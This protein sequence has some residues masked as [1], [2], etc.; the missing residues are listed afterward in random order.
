MELDKF[1]D[2]DLV[3]DHAN[4]N[5]FIPKKF[6]SV[7]DVKGRTL[8]VQITN[9]GV[10]GALPGATMTAVW[11]NKASGI[12]DMSAFNLIDASNS[13]FRLTYPNHMLTAGKVEMT[14]QVLYSGQTTTLKTFEI[15]VQAVNGTFSALIESQQFSALA[16]A[17]ANVNQ[18]DTEIAKKADETIVSGQINDL[19]KS[20]ADKTF[21]DAMLSSI[22]S[23]GPRELFY[24]LS[25]LKAKY[26]SGTEG[27]YLVFDASHTD[28]AHSYMWKDGAWQD[29]GIYQGMEIA[30]GKVNMSKINFNE[31]IVVGHNNVIDF[32][33]TEKR[34][35]VKF[36]TQ[37]ACL[38]NI[39][40]LPAQTIS[41][42]NE[43]IPWQLRYIIY[44]LDTKNLTAYTAAK[45]PTT[46]TNRDV[47]LFTAYNS[48]VVGGLNAHA[49]LV[50]GKNTLDKALT[51]DLRGTSVDV[52]IPILYEQSSFKITHDAA[53]NKVIFECA[54]VYG[55]LQN[56]KGGTEYNSTAP[57]AK[58]DGVFKK[59]A[60]QRTADS[61]RFANN[62]YLS[63]S[64]K[65]FIILDYATKL[66]DEQARDYCFVMTFQND[67]IWSTTGMELYCVIDGKVPKGPL[68]TT[69]TTDSYDWQ[70][71][72]LVI[73]DNLYYVKDKNYT[74]FGQNLVYQQYFDNDNITHE[75]ALPN[76]I[77]EFNQSGNFTPNLAGTFDSKIVSKHKSYD[78]ALIRDI[79]LNIVD[80][81]TKKDKP[82]KFLCIGDSI[83]EA[84][85]SS[86]IKYWLKDWGI[87]AQSLGTANN[88]TDAHE[89]GLMPK[90]PQDYAKG[91]G[92]GGWRLTDFTCKSPL[93]SGGYYEESFALKNPSTNQFDFGYYMTTQAF[94]DLDFVVIQIG[95][96]DITGYHR[97]D[98][99]R[100][101][102][103]DSE[104]LNPSS[105]FYI[106]KQ[107][108]ILI[109]S[110]HAY[111]PTI[112]IALNPPMTVGINASMNLSYRKW[113]EVLIH[114]FKGI[115][116]VYI[117]S[118]Y[119]YQGHMSV[120][121]EPDKGQTVSDTNDTR[122]RSISGD[123]HLNGMGQLVMA[124]HPASW[125]ANL[126]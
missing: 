34:V 97:S 50:D 56:Y 82:V 48:K 90:L 102:D 1:K 35:T 28:G 124:L 25:A 37:I 40:T 112:K 29:L 61:L 20:K 57:Y 95:T 54:T 74:I 26:P 72:R 11:T 110:I 36:D 105:E 60:L 76:Q 103:L 24:S 75:F 4:D 88:A 33:T 108:K 49:I 47:R 101:V 43:D 92:R 16:Q 12:T 66:T 118:S 113:A 10:A 38:N 8:T 100:K 99:V 30:D 115:N 9:N 119:L 67:K 22:A 114:E 65:D 109:D 51:V 81:T 96:N 80:V 19:Q 45:V 64:T 32:D 117:T 31:A 94:S 41:W 70:N 17:L 6:V 93:T 98:T 63:K 3:I 79:R 39:Y 107:Y 116:N 52:L 91:E 53:S 21:V 7:G 15:T 42:K 13:I 46:L 83:V 120:P 62:V 69:V 121:Y 55:L 123:V 85:L 23:D 78:N 27:T 5:T 18:Y 89:Y 59:F 111:D 14:L 122:T 125:M 77:I 73:P 87:N 68:N 126:I 58:V 71:N 106:A 2:V 86:Y 104:Y 84:R 44:N